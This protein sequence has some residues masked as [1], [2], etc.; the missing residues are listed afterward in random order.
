MPSL[1]I[2]IDPMLCSEEA[3]A[4]LLPTPENV[5]AYMLYLNG[6]WDIGIYIN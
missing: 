2:Y 6:T 5:Q 1:E 4:I 3:T